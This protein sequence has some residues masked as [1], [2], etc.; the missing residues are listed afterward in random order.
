MFDKENDLQMSLSTYSL[1][2]WL[3][4]SENQPKYFSLVKWKT[5]A[6]Q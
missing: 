4:T 6:H 1:D 3:M 2:I 5:H